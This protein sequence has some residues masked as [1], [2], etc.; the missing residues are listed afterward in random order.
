MDRKVT[1]LAVGNPEVA[2]VLQVP[3]S[4]NEFL[5]VAK[6][7][8]TTTLFVWLYPEVMKEYVINVSPEDKG[9]ARMI[10][11]AIGLPNVQVKKVGE[12]ILLTGTVR[13]QYER[14]WAV[15]TA[16]LYAGGKTDSSLSVGSGVDM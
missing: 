6:G 8:G 12:R 4:P 16:R 5:I 14:N 10:Q 11:Q 7:A 9:T 1:R 13:N 2:T 15:Q 3:S